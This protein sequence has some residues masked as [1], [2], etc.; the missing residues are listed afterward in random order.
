MHFVWTSFHFSWVEALPQLGKAMSWGAGL[1]WG[2]APPSLPRTEA[3]GTEGFC[4]LPATS[5]GAPPYL[6]QWW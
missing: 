4:D 1:G 2:S 5:A 6:E 3:V